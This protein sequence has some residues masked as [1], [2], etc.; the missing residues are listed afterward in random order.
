MVVCIVSLS[1]VLKGGENGRYTGICSRL[2]SLVFVCR[3]KKKNVC[4]CSCLVCV[5]FLVVLVVLIVF[6]SLF[7][8]AVGFAFAF[9]CFGGL[10]GVKI[11][12]Y[13]RGVCYALRL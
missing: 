12:V 1:I 3:L 13:G 4:Y 7:S 11:V 2:S 10:N 8:V 5:L 6:K 9:G